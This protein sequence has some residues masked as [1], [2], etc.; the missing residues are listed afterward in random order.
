MTLFAQRNAILG[1]GDCPLLRQ[2][3][4]EA[5]RSRPQ[6]KNPLD[7]LLHTALDAVVVMQGDGTIVEWNERSA[8]LFGWTRAEIVGRG[9][10]HSRTGQQPDRPAVDRCRD[11]WAQWPG[12]GGGGAAELAGRIRD[13]LDTAPRAQPA[14]PR[15]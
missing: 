13:L 4:A 2:I 8:E 3:R 1:A 5:M 7:L 10:A 14:L 15:R 12:T 11:A 9:A 6:S